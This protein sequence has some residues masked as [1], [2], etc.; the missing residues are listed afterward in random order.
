MNNKSTTTEVVQKSPEQ[1]EVMQL[2]RCN[3]PAQPVHVT[4]YSSV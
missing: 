2:M 3:S 4:L 1:G